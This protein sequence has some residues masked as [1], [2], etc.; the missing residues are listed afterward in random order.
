MI[1]VWPLLGV[2]LTLYVTWWFWSRYKRL[3]VWRRGEFEINRAVMIIAWSYSIL[4]I[5]CV[6][7]T[8]TLIGVLLN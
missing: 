2:V 3:R 8:A 4:L 7:S 1:F 5:W 6:S